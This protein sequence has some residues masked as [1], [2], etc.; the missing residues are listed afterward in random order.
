MGH[1][2]AV[3]LLLKD[4]TNTLYCDGFGDL[5]DLGKALL[6]CDRLEQICDASFD[7]IASSHLMRQQNSYFHALV[8]DSYGPSLFRISHHRLSGVI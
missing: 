5:R 8:D 1:I 3:T 4:L 7:Y 2:T 6:E